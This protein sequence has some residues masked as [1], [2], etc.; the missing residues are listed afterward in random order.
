[1]S[2]VEQIARDIKSLSRADLAAFRRWFLEFDA[3]MWDRQIEDDL[4]SGK[5]DYLADASLESHKAG[6]STDL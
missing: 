5:L 1:M 6:K 2:R 4:S 3:E